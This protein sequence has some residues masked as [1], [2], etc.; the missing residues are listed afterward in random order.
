MVF[1]IPALLFAHIKFAVKQR[2]DTNLLSEKFIFHSLSSFKLLLL[3]LYVKMI[4]ALLF[5][6]SML[7]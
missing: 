5:D 2:A 4:L 1:S 7:G 6:F 3:F